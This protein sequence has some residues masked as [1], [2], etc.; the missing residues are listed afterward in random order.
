MRGVKVDDGRAVLRE[1]LP[2]PTPQADEALLRVLRAGI[3][4]TDEEI[5]KGYKEGFHCILGHEFVGRVVSVTAVDGRDDPS[6]PY[7][8]R[9][10]VAEINLPCDQD[11]CPACHP[12]TPPDPVQR[13]NH[14]P[15]RTCL[16]II[17]RDGC[18]AD[19]VTVPLANLHLVPDEVSDAAAAFCEPLAAACRL[20]EQ[21]RLRREDRMLV[22]GDGKL[23]LLCAE[24]L[25][26]F[27]FDERFHQVLRQ[28]QSGWNL[29]QAFQEFWASQNAPTPLRKSK[30]MRNRSPVTIVGR[31]PS[32]LALLT[33]THTSQQQQQQQASDAAD[34]SI[35]PP[36]DTMCECRDGD[37]YHE[38]RE[39]EESAYD[40]VVEATGSPNGLKLAMDMVR[41]QGVLFLKT[42]CAVGVEDEGFNMA[43]L[44]VKEVQLVGSRCGPMGVAVGVLEAGL[45]D[46]C[47]YLEAEYPLDRALDALHYAQRKGVLKVQIVCANEGEGEPEDHHAAE[48]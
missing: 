11:T 19:Y 28:H 31:H 16:G 5:L 15:S 22:I 3:C 40:I 42:T 21:G 45:I 12:E 39:K 33:H 27:V 25:Q 17:N 41:P 29:T 6:H 23:G 35:H 34:V 36:I 10:V 24:V 37:R 18:F 48:H 1:D 47:K 26:L 8:S 20:V 13:R 7:L 14:C 2:V 30:T 9:R 46:V 43:P 38:W 4:K 44:V 32:K